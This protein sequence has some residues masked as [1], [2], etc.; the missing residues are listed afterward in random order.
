MAD[1]Y[2]AGMLTTLHRLGK[3]KP[4]RLMAEVELYSTLRPVALV[5]PALY[6]DVMGEA[7]KGIRQ[8]LKAARFIKEIVLTLGPATDEEFSN[9]KRFM[10]EIP[11][12]VKIV[13][14]KGKRLQELY[15]S[16]EERGISAG[17]DGKGRSAWTAYG[18]VL[19]SGK[20]N[21][22]ALHDCDIIN[23]NLELLARLIYP[24]IT[25]TLEFTFCKGY[26][27]RVT[28]K[29][30]GRVTRLF[31]TPLIRALKRIL[32]Q[33]PFL[34]FLDSFR[35]PLSGEFCMTTEVA[36]INRVPWDWGLEV[37]M[38]AE[39][40]RNYSLK[41][42]C[43][44]DITENYEHKHQKLSA[45]DPSAGLM[46]MSIDIAKS[47]FRTL[48]SE[49]IVFSEGFFKTLV[50]AYL[51]IAEDTIKRYESDAAINGLTFDRHEEAMTVDAFTKSITTA[52]RAI[53]EDP[54]GAPLIPNWNRAISAIPG[55]LERLKSAVEEDNK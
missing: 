35:Y 31:V 45:E 27:A 23:Y 18:Y 3:P 32:S 25:P 14:T 8:E 49:G 20:S 28:D 42:I 55:V 29:L 21:V 40:Y 43:Q 33:Q 51:R 13:H 10:S 30:H 48:A 6:S 39:V 44:V 5:L 12:E 11:I 19:A 52:S 1:F 15:R 46:K 37:G 47:L 34:E 7:M 24:V 26:Y 38:L 53:M 16:L 41:R 4:E 2:H 17:P 9:V 54:L 50:S 22:I 36:R